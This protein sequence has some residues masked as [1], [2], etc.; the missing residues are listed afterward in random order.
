MKKLFTLFLALVATTALW[1]EDFVVNGIYYKILADKTKEVEVTFRGV[2][3]TSFD[4]EYSG[5]VTIPS[6]VTY[7]RLTYS[8][9]SIGN[10]AFARCSS[11][12]S[13]TIP[14]SVTNIGQFAFENCSGLT[15]ITIPNS[16]TEIG[17]CAFQGCSGLTSITIPNSVTRIEWQAFR[18]CSSLTSVTIPESVK[19]IGIYAFE[20]TA[21]YNTPSNWDNGALYLGDCL[22]SLTDSYVGDYKIKESTRLIV[23]GAFWGCKSL[24]S[25]TIPTSVTSIGDRTFFDCEGL[26]SVTIPNSVTSIEYGAFYN[27]LS[28]NSVTIPSNVTSIGSYAF[29]NT[30]IYNNESNW[31]KG[32]LY[33]SNCLIN[34]K[35]DISGAY[36]I[37]EG[38]RL[39]AAY[40]F[41][42][43]SGLTSVTIPN[44]VTSVGENAFDGCSGLT[45]ITSLAEVPPTLGTDA[46]Y[47]VS[48]TI[49]V[50]VP[51][52]SLS[53]YQS[54]E[55]WK[56]FTNIQCVPE[57][58]SA[59]DNV[60]SPSANTQKFIRDGQLII[61]RDGVEYNAM[62]VELK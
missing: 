15:S 23:D 51:C 55:G 17:N 52:E 28:L 25:V 30:G 29:V 42:W 2:S 33:I 27:C 47:A 60:H 44:S 9:T 6:T 40:A 45:S 36:I 16:V 41:A 48:N 62:G 49:P 53:D 19:S 7:A 59:V 18:N 26:T 11:L 46:F 12:T 5:S 57:D 24:T 4:N 39:I 31:K 54:A 3:F 32:V 22:V 56:S 50:Y 58:E 61:I 14:E 43:C 10:D 34:A 21:F 1:A 35:D 8:V 13:I 38:T 37:E 20:G